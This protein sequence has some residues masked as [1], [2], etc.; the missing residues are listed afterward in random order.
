MTGAENHRIKWSLKAFYAWV[1]ASSKTLETN[2]N[3][4]QSF[5]KYSTSQSTVKGAVTCDYTQPV[6]TTAVAYGLLGT[7]RPI[8]LVI[9]IQPSEEKYA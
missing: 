1:G 7:P 2:E 5:R 9:Y 8:E 6:S 3:E 4:E